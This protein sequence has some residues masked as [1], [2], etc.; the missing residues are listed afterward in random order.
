MYLLTYLFITTIFLVIHGFTY[1][2]VF[3]T[4]IN[5]FNESNRG[6]YIHN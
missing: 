6:Y 2:A 1:V 4:H 3:Q 5:I